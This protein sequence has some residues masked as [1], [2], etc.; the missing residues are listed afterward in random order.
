MFEVTGVRQNAL[1]A[2]MVKSDIPFTG[3]ER[4]HVVFKRFATQLSS[5]LPYW[6]FL[7]PLLLSG[8]GPRSTVAV[9][10]RIP[11]PD[12]LLIQVLTRRPVSQRP[13]LSLLVGCCGVIKGRPF[14]SC[15]IPSSWFA[16]AWVLRVAGIILLDIG[17]FMYL[18]FRLYIYIYKQIYQFFNN[19]AWNDI[20]CR[21]AD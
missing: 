8:V 18:C 6:I 7:P 12:R 11:H 20:M 13:Q 3:L 2:V 9:Q 1:A 5:A 17:I 14:Y 21:I 15:L 10:P 4:V 16:A 19:S